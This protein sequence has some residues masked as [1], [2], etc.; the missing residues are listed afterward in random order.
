[1]EGSMA[2]RSI[3]IVGGGLAGLSTGIYAAANGYSTHIYEQH[4]AA[5]GVCTAWARGDYIFDCSLHFLMGA[6]PGCAL[7]ALYDEV[8]ALGAGGL[9]R[10][11]RY[12]TAVDEATG[13]RLDVTSDLDRLSADLRALSPADSAFVDRLLRDVRRFVGVDL[14]GPDVAPGIAAQ[15]RAMWQMRRVF[16]F[17]ARRG[18]RS[19]GQVAQAVR[20]RFVHLVVMNLFTPEVPYLFLL[21]LLAG[22]ANGELA[23]IEGGSA[24]FAGAIERRYRALGGEITFGAMV[25]EILVEN[26]RAVGVRLADGSVH[27]ADVVV[28]AADGRSTIFDMLG[29]R[30]ADARVRTRYNTWPIFAP[31]VLVD[32]GLS[33]KWPPSADATMVFLET[34]LQVAGQNVGEFFVRTFSHDPKFAPEGHSVAQVLMTGHWH[35]WNRLSEDRQ[36]YEAEK[37]R[38]AE[39]LAARLEPYLPGIRGAI[40]EV[41]VATPRTFWRYTRNYRGA[42]EGFMMTPKTLTTR[43]PKMLPGLAGFYMAGQWV[44]PGGGVPT[45]IGSGKNVVRLICR[46]DRQ[47]FRAPA[48]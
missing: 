43:V 13:R 19:V 28:S 8:G 2:G 33:K 44:E 11:D 7:H 34:P 6:R 10:I 38:V 35:T 37:S 29:G 22:L 4:S 42:Y 45:V 47:Q 9:T 40:E 15:A 12:A 25:Q 36:A 39:E 20:D 30:Y 14:G 17:L 21:M 41:D 31:I 3:A 32:F 24:G 16:T 46:A 23:T 1:M 27:R 18:N 26:D 48:V 5:G